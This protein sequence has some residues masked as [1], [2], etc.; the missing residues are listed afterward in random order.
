[1][2]TPTINLSSQ[3]FRIWQHLIDSKTLSLKPFVGTQTMCPN[4]VV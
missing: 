4:K 1:M 2:L 3:R